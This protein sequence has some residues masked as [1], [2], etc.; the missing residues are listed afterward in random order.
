MRLDDGLSP[1][2]PRRESNFG[3]GAEAGRSRVCQL[4]LLGECVSD[5]ATGVIAVDDRRRG[6]TE[7]C[8]VGGAFA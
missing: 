6:V 5:Y 8:L 4:M 2:L 1:A 7:E 3:E